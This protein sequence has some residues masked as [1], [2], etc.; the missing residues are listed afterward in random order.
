MGGLKARG[1]WG[2]LQ[3]LILCALKPGA[4]PQAGMYRAFGAGRAVVQPSG[5]FQSWLEPTGFSRWLF[6]GPGRLPWYRV[7]CVRT[8]AL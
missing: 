7:S 3:P 1:L 5:D 6:S 2:G 4:L 8:P